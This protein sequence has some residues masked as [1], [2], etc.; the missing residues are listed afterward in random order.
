MEVNL[1]RNEKPLQT[2]GGGRLMHQERVNQPVSEEGE[3][4][5]CSWVTV[6]LPARPGQNTHTH[7]QAGSVE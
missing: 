1:V 4:H 5:F 2:L 7:L 3:E 6:S